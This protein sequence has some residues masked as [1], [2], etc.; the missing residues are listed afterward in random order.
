MIIVDIPKLKILDGVEFNC[1]NMIGG[2]PVVAWI[3]EA[4]VLT[5]E[6][7]GEVF[8]GGDCESEPMAAELRVLRNH[9][10]S[11]SGGEGESFTVGGVFEFDGGRVES[12][13]N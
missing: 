9:G 3:E 4:E 2:I 10:E 13:R 11:E 6:S 1:E 12:V 7:S 8:G 5:G